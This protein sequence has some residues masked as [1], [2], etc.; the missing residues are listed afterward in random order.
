MT[1]VTALAR[2]GVA[3]A[4]GPVGGVAVGGYLDGR[5]VVGTQGGPGQGP[6]ALLALRFDAAPTHWLGGHLELRT[7]VGGP[8]EGGHGG[9]LNFDHAFQK[10]SPSLEIGE[11][12]ADLRLSEADVRVGVQRFAWGKLDG[13]PPTDVLNPHDYH[14]PLLDDVEEAKIGVP[15]VR[16]TYYLPDLPRFDIAGVAATLIY[17]PLA[18]PSRLALLDE[19][20]FPSAAVLAGRAHVPPSRFD[21]PQPGDGDLMVETRHFPIPF[22]V[23][24]ENHRPPLRLDAGAIGFRLGG[25]W[26]DVD[27]DF[28]HYSGPETAPDAD[29]RV[30]LA[31][32][33]KD[34]VTG[35]VSV[36]SSSPGRTVVDIKKVYA[37][38]DL[39]QAHDTIHMTG[40]DWAAAVGGFT[41]RAEA[42]YFQDRPYLR[43]AQDLTSPA[44]IRNL[45]RTHPG[46]PRRFLTQRAI[47]L[48]LGALFPQSDS[49][50]WGMGAD[51][52][53]HGY[54]PLLQVSQVALLDSLPQLAISD[55]ETRLVASLRKR[56]LADRMEVEV[57]GIFTLDRHS[58]FVLPQV[59]YLIHDSLRLRLGYL[60]IGG[61]DTSLIGQF[62]QNDEL[63]LEARY[64]F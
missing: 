3:S 46:L 29:L 39:R 28:Y 9:V 43:V 56:Y 20:W 15:A 62:N 17:V 23:A 49:V 18:V 34:F 45:L 11:A 14:D 38:A 37:T 32:R 55:P 42:A 16:S 33:C 4:V 50:E 58:W 54:L 2:P 5:A 61:P 12:Y 6:G 63:V 24:T 48:P 27:W 30:T 25:T 7:R 21:L 26:R 60:A 35:C 64:T 36:V 1:L 40:A 10:R 31:R 53:W 13:L 47:V 19:R 52:L 41:L 44:A 59:S 51:Y 57:R 8:F 22:T